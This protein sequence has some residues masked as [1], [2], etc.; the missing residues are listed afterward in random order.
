MISYASRGLSSEM[1]IAKL[2]SQKAESRERNKTQVRAS[3]E[4]IISFLI[5]PPPFLPLPYNDIPAA[6]GDPG[7]LEGAHL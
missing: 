1:Y 2:I 3:C 6:R 5:L 7:A 4:F